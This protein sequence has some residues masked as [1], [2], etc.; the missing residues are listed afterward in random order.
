MPLPEV[1]LTLASPMPAR[2]SPEEERWKTGCAG[3]PG[4]SDILEPETDRACP[5]V[6]GACWK[7]DMEFDRFIAE[8]GMGMAEAL[9]LML[10]SV[11][12]LSAVDTHV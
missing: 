5:P 3:R 2:L 6:C 1:R 12:I 8:D 10:P 9:L 7:F 11:C 4:A